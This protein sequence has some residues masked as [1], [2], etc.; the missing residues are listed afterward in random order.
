MWSQA[1]T[2]FMNIFLVQNQ[3]LSRNQIA[4]ISASKI[5]HLAFQFR[6]GIILCGWRFR[7]M[8]GMFDR[9]QEKLWMLVVEVSLTFTSNPQINIDIDGGAYYKTWNILAI[10]TGWSLCSYLCEDL[11]LSWVI[12]L[13]SS[14]QN[15]IINIFESRW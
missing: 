14:L 5:F 8:I 10:W 11:I 3:N 4:F 7:N 6:F 2:F 13:N 9:G 1:R 15:N 12:S